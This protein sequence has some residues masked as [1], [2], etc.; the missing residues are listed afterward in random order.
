MGCQGFVLYYN[1]SEKQEMRPITLFHRNK[2]VL[3]EW[4][5]ILVAQTE[6]QSFEKTYIMGR[7]IGR[8]KFS[9]VCQCTNRNSGKIEAVKI[10]TIHNLK[11]KE[12][13][14]LR[15]EISILKQVS[16]P[17]VIQI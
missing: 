12:C 3:D 1:L 5:S 6:N 11:P 7:E 15:E 13:M 16:H 10:I 9:K 14:I 4:F 2:E 17:Y 8:G